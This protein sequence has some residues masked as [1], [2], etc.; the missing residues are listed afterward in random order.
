MKPFNGENRLTPS[1]RLGVC[2]AT[3]LEPMLRSAQLTY[4]RSSAYLPSH[5]LAVSKKHCRYEV[6]NEAHGEDRDQG[7]DFSYPIKVAKGALP[8]VTFQTKLMETPGC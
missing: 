3:H 2:L 5:R 7:R 1:S 6:R 8:L 4:M